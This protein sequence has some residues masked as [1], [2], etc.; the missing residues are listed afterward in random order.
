[1]VDVESGT[2]AASLM[3]L[4]L[5]SDTA[6]NSTKSRPAVFPDV[7]VTQTLPMELPSFD[8]NPK[9]LPAPLEDAVE[10]NWPR[11]RPDVSKTESVIE[12]PAVKL[13]RPSPTAF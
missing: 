9:K 1:M 8:T 5:N 7:P 10:L 13:R 6:P 11:D 4:L 2:A 12:P 3:A